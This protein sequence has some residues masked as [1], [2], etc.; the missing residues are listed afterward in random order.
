MNNENNN[1]TVPGPTSARGELPTIEAVRAL[2]LSMELDE[3]RLV[4]T[5]LSRVIASGRSKSREKV[6]QMNRG[7]LACCR[8]EGVR[9]GEPVSAAH[10]ELSEFGWPAGQTA[11]RKLGIDHLLLERYWARAR[12]RASDASLPLNWVLAFVPA[13][14]WSAVLTVIR[15]GPAE[16]GMRLEDAVIDLAQ[17]PLA[18]RS[19]RRSED[20]TLSAGTINTRITGIHHLFSAL[21]ELRARA[22]TSSNS[23][24]S[25]ELLEP[26]SS[27]PE[28]PDLDLCGAKWAQIDTSGPSFDEARRLLTRLDAEVRAAPRHS[29]YHRLRRRAIAALLLAH[30]PRVEALRMLNV[31][32]YLP[33][34]NFGDGEVGP[35]V[36]Y[37]P[38]KTRAANER[39]VLALPAE[40]AAW[41]EEWIR[42]TGRELGQAGSPMWPHR[43]PKQGQPIL[44]L[45]AS[46]FARTI[47]G[48]QATDGTGSTPLL[49]R[50]E[51]PYIGYNPHA[52]RHTAYQIARR[53]GAQAKLEDPHSYAHVSPDDFAAA[54]VGHDLVRSVGDIYRDLNPEHLARIAI[55]YAWSDLRVQPTQL[56]PDLAAIEEACERVEL[57]NAALAELTVELGETERRQGVIVRESAKLAGDELEAARLQSNTLVFELAGLQSEVA[58]TR[59][60][61]ELARLDLEHALEND[62]VHEGETDDSH[63]ERLEEMSARARAALAADIL[64][65]DDQL[66]V[67]ELS[68][69]VGTT[70]KTIN[71]WVRNGFP[72]RRQPLW[73]DGAWT[74]DARGIRALPVVCLKRESLTPIQRERLLLT[75]LRH[76]RTSTRQAA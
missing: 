39:H 33:E 16:A 72:A 61:L 13:P 66:S 43:K 6:A 59:S 29:R 58:M 15:W 55:G 8:V 60:R 41:L 38:G 40:A 73:E 52:Y 4:L 31:A 67:R 69:I 30:G 2:G 20:A 21:V 23:G 28:R 47:S 12:T 22:L 74:A 19:R 37:R 25:L 17:R 5:C 35:A 49:Q 32:D 9:D 27:K 14:L 34:H 1:N 70:E 36:V 42:Y 18:T 51:D 3:A 48:H 7:V 45:N 24:L 75:Q 11:L 44:R 57:L 63:A 50:G 46:A 54:V 62:V 68:R 76:A 71:S 65:G 56:G 64:A 10:P 26:W 53:A